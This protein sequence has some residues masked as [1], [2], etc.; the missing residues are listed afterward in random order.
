M[1]N[2]FATGTRIRMDEVSALDDLLGYY[3]YPG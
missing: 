1:I 2:A 3:H